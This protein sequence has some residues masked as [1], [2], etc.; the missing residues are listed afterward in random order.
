MKDPSPQ[1]EGQ[2]RPADDNMNEHM[3]SQA[4]LYRFL[5]Y[6]ANLLITSNFIAVFTRYFFWIF[7]FYIIQIL[8]KNRALGASVEI[9]I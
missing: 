9:T 1:R 4:I 3:P 6:I 8:Y 5:A 7:Q 2:S